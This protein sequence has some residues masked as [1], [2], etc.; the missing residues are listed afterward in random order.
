MSAVGAPAVSRQK[1]E[2]QSTG[3]RSTRPELSVWTLLDDE[4]IEVL[5][6]FGKSEHRECVREALGVQSVMHDLLANNANVWRDELDERARL[7]SDV[8]NSNQSESCDSRLASN[9]LLGFGRIMKRTAGDLRV[10]WEKKV[11]CLQHIQHTPRG[12]C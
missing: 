5:G 10:S 7:C 12:P 2:T 4:Q 6:L 9:L 1:R 11:R 8:C 3:S